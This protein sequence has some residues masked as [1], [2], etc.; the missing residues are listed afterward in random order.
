M[1][2]SGAH[3][4]FEYQFCLYRVGRDD[5]TL[6]FRGAVL[7]VAP[8]VVKTLVILLDHPGRFVAKD[9]LLESVWDGSVV[10]E[11]NLSQNIYTLRRI[12][13]AT[14]NEVFIETLPRRGYRFNGSVVRRRLSEKPARSAML[15]PWLLGAVTAAIIGGALAIRHGA[16]SKPAGQ[17]TAQVS[18]A[19]EQEYALG[20]YYWRDSTSNGLHASVQHFDLVANATP[21]S[22][23]G[24]AG[25]AA[26]YAK[27][28]DIYEGSPTGV[29]DSVKAWK[30]SQQALALDPNSAEALAV[31][32]FIEFDLDG[33]NRAA[34]ADL[35]RAVKIQPDLAVAR[36]WYGAVL[37]WEGKPL[38]ARV[39]LER[40]SA[41]DS[42]L[43]SLDY[44]LALDFYMSRDYKNAIAFAKLATADEWA[45]DFSRFLLAAAHEEAGQYQLAIKDVQNLSTSPSEALAVS[46]TLAHVYASMGNYA[47]ARRE[48]GAVERLSERYRHR[49][50]LT[51]VAYIANERPDEAF[52]WLYSPAQIR[53][54]ALCARPA[55]PL[56]PFLSLAAWLGGDEI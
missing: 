19:A 55:P 13:E 22:P 5:L 43:P 51:A 40:A 56:P 31:K 14:S 9:E 20:W 3:Q 7:P 39:E 41:L 2:E 21:R 15:N 42:R 25:E 33:D 36:V 54:R 34:A 48:L 17:P 16:V 37:L 24:Y 29:T 8:K 26:A 10:E 32:G 28:A 44:L 52:A 1:P 12:F 18:A 50:V 4:R 45:G 30:L 49:P 47:L 27:L 11:A 46:G 6:R 53:S 23:L 38:A 35:G